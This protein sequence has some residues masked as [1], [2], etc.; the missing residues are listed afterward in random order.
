VP[1]NVC[2]KPKTPTIDCMI[3]ARSAARA[4]MRFGD[5]IPEERL[6]VLRDHIYE[7]ALVSLKDDET[8][9]QHENCNVMTING[10]VIDVSSLFE[11]REE[12]NNEDN[13][14][15]THGEVVIAQT[16]SIETF[17]RQWRDHFVTSM[18]PKYLPLGWN[19]KHGFN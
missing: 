6:A 13:G 7:W 9:D 16:E 14:R 3:N 2:D 1:L 5:T 17:I 11:P 18:R 15:S 8:S 4:I 12:V 19:T 10:L